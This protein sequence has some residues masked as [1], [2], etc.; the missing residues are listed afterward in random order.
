[1]ILTNLLKFDR[2]DHNASTNFG[3]DVIVTTVHLLEAINV[4]SKHDGVLIDKFYLRRFGN[5][6]YRVF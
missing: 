5:I 6:G 3:R 2:F 4:C 1:M